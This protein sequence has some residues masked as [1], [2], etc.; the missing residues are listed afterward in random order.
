MPKRLSAICLFAAGLC[1]SGAALD[2]LQVFAWARMF[3]AYAHQMSVQQAATE[4]MDGS[5]PCSLCRALRRV[6]N[7]SQR[8]QPAAYI[9][10]ITTKLILIADKPARLVFARER[11]AWPDVHAGAMPCRVDP[12]PLPPPRA[13]VT[14]LA[15]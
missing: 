4:T 1:A 7:E 11:E 2:G 5:K 14:R 3:C 8:D 6:R 12:V 13:L 15:V 9:A 10:G